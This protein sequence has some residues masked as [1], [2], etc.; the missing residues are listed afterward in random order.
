MKAISSGM[1]WLRR[2]RHQQRESRSTNIQI[3]YNQHISVDE[4]LEVFIPIF[5]QFYPVQEIIDMIKKSDH[6]FCAYDKNTG[7]CVACA[8]VNDVKR[9]DDLYIMLFGVRRSEQ[10]RGT[11]T[12]LL[13]R[14][15]R[16]AF[17]MGYQN[18]RL[19]VNVSNE[20]AI[21]LYTKVGFV[22]EKRVPFFYM[23]LPKKSPHGYS[24]V[25]SFF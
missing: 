15:I 18:I 20:P 6:V 19:H 22:V 21:G 4:I 13:K 17:Q 16:W 23:S 14:V 9:K 7:R 25:L 2:G 5:G 24:M 8:L 1:Q 11:G 10:G 12:L 3:Y